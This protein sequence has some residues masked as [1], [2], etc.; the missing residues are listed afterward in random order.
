MLGAEV[1]EYFFSGSVILAAETDMFGSL[2]PV[3]A[4]TGWAAK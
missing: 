2:G 1:T 3:A 4:I